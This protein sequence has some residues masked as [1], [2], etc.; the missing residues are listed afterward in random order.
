M[1]ANSPVVVVV[2]FTDEVNPKRI[3]P[4]HVSVAKGSAGLKLDSG[5][6]AEQIGA[7]EVSRVVTDC[8]KLA[9]SQV[10]QLEEA[11]RITLALR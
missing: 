1:N 3:F 6:K 9:E 5:A 4:S 11:I 2:A 10:H 8:G 7:M